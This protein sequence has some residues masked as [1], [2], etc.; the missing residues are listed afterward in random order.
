MNRTQ[1]QFILG[2][3]P[4]GRPLPDDPEVAEALLL[5]ETDPELARWWAATRAFDS[6]VAGTLRTVAPP[7]DLR[8]A[9]L[10][11]LRFTPP[12]AH[13]PVWRQPAWL[14]L[15]AL[16]VVLLTGAGMWFGR[17]QTA[18]TAFRRDV[19]KFMS[20]DW[21]HDFDFP[22]ASFPKICEWAARQP[23]GIQLQAPAQLAG[24][25]TFGCKIF[26]WRGRRAT[27]VCFVTKAEG[28]VIHVVS[29]DRAALP[30][31]EIPVPAGAP[32]FARAGEWNTALWTQGPRLY[33][34]LTTMNT[35]GLARY[36]KPAVL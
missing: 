36:V 4:P 27:L 2:A 5:L 25:A 30:A 11:G 22:E 28:E 17:Q 34:A 1:A 33:V 12:P 14:A 35:E 29:V 26:E 23:G 7:A 8:D 15:A 13:R 10:A 32:Q 16:F 3:C 31:T 20:E 6:S 18:A 24:N 19:A 21:Q 9:I